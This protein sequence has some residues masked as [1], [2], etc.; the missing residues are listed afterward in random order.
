MRGAIRGSGC[1]PAARSR[2]Q[3]PRSR[4]AAN[5]ARATGVVAAGRTFTADAGARVM[6][7]GGNA[8]RRGESPSIFARGRHRE[9]RTSGLGGRGRRSSFTPRANKGASSSSTARAARPQA[10]NPQ[11]FAGKDVIP[12]QR[13][14]RRD[15]FPRRS[16]P[17]RSRWRRT[18]RSLSR[19]SCQPG[20]RAGRR[21]FPDVRVPCITTFETERKA[22]EPYAWTMQTYYPGGRI[23]PVG[24]VFRQPNLAATL[25]ALAAAE[26]AALASGASREQAIQA[27]RDAFY[28]GADRAANM[29]AARAAK[30]AASM[31]EG[32]PGVPTPE[33]S[34]RPASAPYRG[35]TIY[36]AGFWNSG[37]LAAADA[38]DPRR[39]RPARHGARASAD[40][41]AHD[42]RS[43]QARPYADRG[44]AI[45]AIRISSRCRVDVLLSG[46]Y[47]AARRGPD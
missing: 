19:T 21:L 35:Y 45:T 26:K 1:W 20:Y 43:D 3:G 38:A 39:L 14:A 12:R 7:A 34:K 8:N 41:P 33:R 36:K 18:E 37:A 44:P 9:S 23:T 47:A 5:S 25:R 17:R 32:D 16:T 10:A 15:D 40:A 28:K 42:G 6:A 31:T 2:P 30:P 46:P 29:T 13:P 22:C 11:L 24:E 4:C 27:G